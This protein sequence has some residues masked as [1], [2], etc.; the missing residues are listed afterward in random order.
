MRRLKV[1]PRCLVGRSFSRLAVRFA[2]YPSRSATAKTRA[3]VSS[4]A[5]GAPRKTMETSAVETPAAAATSRIVGGP[6]TYRQLGYRHSVR[7]NVSTVSALSPRNCNGNPLDPDPEGA[8][9]AQDIY[10]SIEVAAL[11]GVKRGV[12]MSGAPGSEPSSTLPVWNVVP[13]HSAFLRVR[14]Y[15]WNEVAVPFWRKVQAFAA[16]HDVKVCLDMHPGDVVFNAHAGAP[17]HGGR[18]DPRGRRDGPGHLFWQGIAPTEAVRSL[19]G[20]VC[21]AAAKDTR[22]NPLSRHGTSPPW[23][24]RC[25]PGHWGG[26]CTSTAATGV[27]TQRTRR[28]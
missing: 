7:P 3:R 5:P 4:L 2:R 11:L 24:S 27:T 22:I 26:C 13:W 8:K 17:G 16:D 6:P 18:C 19:G 28:R 15:Q 25:D 12:T 14:D 20:L 21:N 23:P 9:Q 10:T 1:T